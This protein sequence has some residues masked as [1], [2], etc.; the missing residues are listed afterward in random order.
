MISLINDILCNLLG[1][2]ETCY[3][4]GRKLRQ[5]TIDLI[6]DWMPFEFPQTQRGKIFSCPRKH[7]IYTYSTKTG[8]IIS[9]KYNVDKFIIENNYYDVMGRRQPV[10]GMNVLWKKE[11]GDVEKL[12]IPYFNIE[13]YS[14]E[15]VKRKIKLYLV[16]S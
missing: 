6:E 3:R 5:N 12:V 13:K 9:A 11:N 10:N 2:G 14:P 16:F 8:K 7:T 1:N 15:Q 4:C